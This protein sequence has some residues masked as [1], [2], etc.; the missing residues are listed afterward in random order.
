M[1]MEERKMERKGRSIYKS[2]SK[3][4]SIFCLTEIGEG[5]GRINYPTNEKEKPSAKAIIM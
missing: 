5:G 4:A 1:L 3:C 2:V